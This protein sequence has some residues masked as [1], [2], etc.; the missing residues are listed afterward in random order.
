M[1]GY[2]VNDV[3]IYIWFFG[4]LREKKLSVKLLITSV[5]R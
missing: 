5:G 4:G 2:D 3:N 1:F